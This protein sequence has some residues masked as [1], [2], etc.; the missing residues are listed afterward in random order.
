MFERE[1]SFPLARGPRARPPGRRPGRGRATAGRHGRPRRDDRAGGLRRESG[2]VACSRNLRRSRT[3]P[4]VVAQLP[5]ERPRGGRRNDRRRHGRHDVGGRRLPGGQHVHV[6]VRPTRSDHVRKLHDRLGATASAPARPASAGTATAGTATALATSASSSASSVAAA[7][8]PARGR[9]PQDFDRAPGLEAVP[10]RP[11]PD[12]PSGSRA[13]RAHAG[14]THAR[15]GA[16]AVG[17]RPE[18]DPGCR[19]QSTSARTVD[20]RAP[21]RAAA[22]Q[23]HR[24]HRLAFPPCGG[25]RSSPSRPGSLQRS[26][27]RSS[28]LARRSSVCASNGHR[29][30]PTASSSSWA[31][32]TSTRESRTEPGAGLPIGSRRIRPF[33]TPPL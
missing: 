21:R 30:C 8:T 32:P 6:Q 4:V 28:R 11:R 17:R 25:P 9:R 1:G 16:Q 29:R 10:G 20:G 12:Q 14:S 13:A 15:V 24:A 5:L 2:D 18:H 26:R 7:C 33:A 31:R 3:R 27:L 23:A 22:L 19:S